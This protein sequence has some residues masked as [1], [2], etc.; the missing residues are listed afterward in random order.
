[1]VAAAAENLG[2]TRNDVKCLFF[3]LK[4]KLSKKKAAG[5]AREKIYEQDEDE[6][7]DDQTNFFLVFK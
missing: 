6:Y 5:W 4:I 2:P 1:M 3:T 7:A